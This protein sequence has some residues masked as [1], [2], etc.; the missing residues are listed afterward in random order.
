MYRV[1]LLVVEGHPSL[2]V[3]V[4]FVPLW[5]QDRCW[6]GLVRPAEGLFQERKEVY[7]L[8]MRPGHGLQCGSLGGVVGGPAGS[9]RIL[10]RVWASVGAGC[11]GPVVVAV[12]RFRPGP[13]QASRRSMTP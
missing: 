8:G 6:F 1:R 12:G 11:Q 10:M 2:P 9:L 7:S 3:G 13:R 4:V 5:I